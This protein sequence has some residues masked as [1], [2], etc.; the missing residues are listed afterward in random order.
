MLLILVSSLNALA[1]VYP[2]TILFKDGHTEKGFV[3]SFLEDKLINLELIPSLEHELNLDDKNLKFKT[4]ENEEFK[5]IPID[6]IDEVT[7]L[8]KEKTT[9]YKVIY[10]K[11]ISIKGEVLEEGRKVFLPL[12][13]KGKINIYG[14]KYTETDY[15]SSGGIFR[16]KGTRFYYQ[17]AKENYAINYYNMEM[18]EVLFYIKSR[19]LNPLRE[20]FKDC[21]EIVNDLN[22][23]SFE[24]MSQRKKENKQEAK[25]LQKEFKNLSNEEQS[26]MENIHHYNFNFMEKYIAEYESKCN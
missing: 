6:Y 13:K 17:N 18:G 19:M 12:I 3:K 11:E 10:L 9:T 8:D 4:T 14:I 1:K 16:Y 26:K 2:G 5:D 21:P 25:L 22:D 24:G 23:D 20:L 15:D 7:L